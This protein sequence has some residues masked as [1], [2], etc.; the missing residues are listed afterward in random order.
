MAKNRARAA[1]FQ[2]R[3]IA[4]WKAFL[5]YRDIK[6]FFLFIEQINAVLPSCHSILS[7]GLLRLAKQVVPAAQ[8]VT[9]VQGNDSAM[10]SLG[11]KILKEARNA[12][13]C[14]SAVFEADFFSKNDSEL[15]DKILMEANKGNAKNQRNHHCF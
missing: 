6:H 2:K 5:F 4:D 3:Y 12:G 8:H 11:T 15:V 14:V 1:F 10:M 13:L 7:Q 9:V